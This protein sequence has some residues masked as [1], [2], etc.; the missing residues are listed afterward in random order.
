M[1]LKVDLEKAYDRIK[2]E[3]L[4][5]TLNLVGFSSKLIEVIMNCQ[6]VG[7]I[8]LLWTGAMTGQFR[9]TRSVRHGDPLS[10]YLFV[11]CMERLSHV[12]EEAVL[13]GRWEPI[14]VGGVSLSHLFFADDLLL[15][16]EAREDHV[17]M[18]QP[19]RDYC[20]GRADMGEVL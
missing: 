14:T 8:K 20:N 12:I 5:D 17:D 19:T 15:F 1:V 2:W 6:S 9:A 18:L 7:S 3:F 10:P 16:A 11:M 13:E 4:W